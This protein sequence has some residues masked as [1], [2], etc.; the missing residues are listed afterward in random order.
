MDFKA[1][2]DWIPRDALFKCLEVRLQ[3]RTI[4]NILKALYSGTKAF[5]KG[6]KQLFETQVGCR[7]GALESPIL[8]NIYMDFVVR[9]AR[10]E[11]QKVYPNA[12]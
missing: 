3:A 11:I 2:Y 1:A 12:A 10:H 4:V 6:S 5:I 7:Q 9:V 8:F